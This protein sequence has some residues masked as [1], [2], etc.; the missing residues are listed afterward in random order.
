MLFQHGLFDKA[1]A[2]YDDLYHVPAFVRWPGQV[3]PGRYGELVEHVDLIPLIYRAAGRPVPEALSGA[4]LLGMLHGTTAPRKSV[5][6]EHFH[7][8]MLRTRA[9]KLVNYAGREY[10]ELYDLAADPHELHNLWD[11]PAAAELRARLMKELADRLTWDVDPAFRELVEP[12]NKGAYG[13][14]L[15]RWDDLRIRY[16]R[17]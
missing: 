17:K 8:R 15:K 10:G 16:L 14:Y 11:Q 7:M 4:D 9:A 1:F 5:V 6:G 2:V 13:D 12:T 3:R